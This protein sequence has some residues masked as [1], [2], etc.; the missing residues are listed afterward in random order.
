MIRWY[1]LE[2]SFWEKVSHVLL[3]K[4][5]RVLFKFTP[6]S[7]NHAVLKYESEH[8][9]G[10]YTGKDQPHH[11]MNWLWMNKMM[12]IKSVSFSLSE[13]FLSPDSRIWSS[14][15][16]LQS[17][18]QSCFIWQYRGLPCSVYKAPLFN[19]AIAISLRG[20]SSIHPIFPYYY[21]TVEICPASVDSCNVHVTLPVVLITYLVLL[22]CH[23]LGSQ[24]CV[25]SLVTA[26]RSS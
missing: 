10:Y 24:K 11:N 15:K 3:S 13:P 25:S 1:C 22:F 23:F 26:S 20:I 8:V 19:K 16:C 21:Y 14:S 7:G 5:F 4:E 17:Y 9:T 2:F 6:E 18:Y 12:L